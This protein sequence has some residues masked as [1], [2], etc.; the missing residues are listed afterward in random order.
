[1]LDQRGNQGRFRPRVML[2]ESLTQFGESLLV[3]LMDI[4]ARMLRKRLMEQDN[5]VAHYVRNCLQQ[6]LLQF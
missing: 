5:E 3:E 2:V 1:M 6:L 4:S